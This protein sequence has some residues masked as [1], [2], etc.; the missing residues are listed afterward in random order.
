M[1]TSINSKIPAIEITVVESRK[2]QENRTEQEVLRGGRKKK[3]EACVLVLT[4]P[5]P[6]SLCDHQGI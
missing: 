1:I 2:N 6:D 3:E 5:L 4:L